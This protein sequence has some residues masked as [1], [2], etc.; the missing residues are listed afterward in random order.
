MAD[1]TRIATNIAALQSL[2]SLQN[3]NNKLGVAQL[4]LSTGKRINSAADDAAGLTIATKFDFKAKGLGQVLSNIADAKSLI[5]V[6]EGHLNNI[7]DILT[8]MKTK[9]TQAANDTLGSDERTAIS[10]ELKQLNTQIDNEV[11]QAQ[12][13]GANLLV[14]ANCTFAS[15]TTV[16]DFNFQVGVGT[17]TADK[18]SFQIASQVFGTSTTAKKMCFNS[19]S[20]HVQ[21]TA[22]DFA[23]QSGANDFMKAVDKASL[24]VSEGLSYIGAIVNRLDYQEASLSVAKVNTEASWNR[25]MNADMAYEQLEATKYQ[26]L[27][28]TAVTMLAQANMG[29]QAILGLF[30]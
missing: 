14:G 26:I 30:R 12:W 16:G 5:S 13:A 1:F 11:R 18:M 24:K 8:K 10:N 15:T 7:N 23:S 22:S 9:A 3:I 6:A 25:I 17:A 4:R 27:Q 20:L 2:N 28:Q 29:P 21:A 19:K